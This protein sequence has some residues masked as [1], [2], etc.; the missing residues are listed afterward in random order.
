MTEIV[1]LHA[2]RTKLTQLIERA[3]SGEEIIIAKAGEPLVKLVPVRRRANARVPGRWRGK[4][5]MAKDFND[6]PDD[7]L[8]AFERKPS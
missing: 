3:R 4:V 8:D 7:I 5:W 6:L 2:A 1:N